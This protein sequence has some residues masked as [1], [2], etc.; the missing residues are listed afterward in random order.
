M[1]AVAATV[2]GCEAGKCSGPGGPGT[3][4][5]F[6]DFSESISPAALGSDPPEKAPWA[7]GCAA[8]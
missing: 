6:G 2:P 8:P 4:P 1:E 3:G 7:E 5:D